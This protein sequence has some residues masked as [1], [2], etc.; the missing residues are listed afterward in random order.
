MASNILHTMGT[1]IGSTGTGMKHNGGRRRILEA[2]GT[3]MKH[4]THNGD[5]YWQA[6][7]TDIGRQW[8]RTLEAMGTEIITFVQRYKL[9]G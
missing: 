9:C 7:V 5:G 2:M 4:I 8:G 1:D 3:G 6:I